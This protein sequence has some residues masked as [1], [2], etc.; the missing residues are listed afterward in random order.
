MKKFIVFLLMFGLMTTAASAAITGTLSP[1]SVS[2]VH[3]ANS[4][5]H[6]C[7]PRLAVGALPTN[8]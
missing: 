3:A 2:G 6:S 4:L 7:D 5:S 1:D 8:L